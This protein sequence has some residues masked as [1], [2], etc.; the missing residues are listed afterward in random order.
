MGPTEAAGVMGVQHS[1]SYMSPVILASS[2]VSTIQQFQLGCGQFVENDHLY[3]HI[4][5]A[6]RLIFGQIC[7][8][9]APGNS[10]RMWRCSDSFRDSLIAHQRVGRSLHS[11]FYISGCMYNDSNRRSHVSSTVI[12]VTPQAQHHQ[13]LQLLLPQLV[14]QW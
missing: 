11:L 13:Q 7:A 6:I 9:R 8:P 10:C 12:I 2:Q 5:H 1:Q 14:G 4:L 3:H